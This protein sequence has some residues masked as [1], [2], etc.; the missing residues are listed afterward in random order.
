MFSAAAPSIETRNVMGAR[1]LYREFRGP[2]FNRDQV[3]LTGT[4]YDSLSLCPRDLREGNSYADQTECLHFQKNV[5]WMKFGG[6]QFE[7]LRGYC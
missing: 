1:G 7:T 2:S 5:G 4:L 6:T 3:F